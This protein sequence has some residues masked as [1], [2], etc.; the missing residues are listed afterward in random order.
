[1]EALEEGGE[2]DVEEVRHDAVHR[3]P[4]GPG[5]VMLGP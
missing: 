4:D 1:M 3:R 5:E 2:V